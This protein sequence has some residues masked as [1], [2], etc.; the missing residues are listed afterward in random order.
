MDESLRRSSEP[1]TAVLT[2]YTPVQNKSLKFGRKKLFGEGGATFMPLSGVQILY[3]DVFTMV[4]IQIVQ[5][6]LSWNGEEGPVGIVSCLDYID[7]QSWLIKWFEEIA[8]AYA[9]TSF[10]KPPLSGPLIYLS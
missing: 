5:V 8:Q 6:N 3:K 10:R 2:G 9:F 4:F 7:Y 1:S